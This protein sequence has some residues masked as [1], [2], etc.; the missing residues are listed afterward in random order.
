MYSVSITRM[1]PIFVPPCRKAKRGNA[2][3]P[4]FD[5]GTLKSPIFRSLIC[6]ALTRCV[7]PVGET[8]R[9]L[10]RLRGDAERFEKSVGE[11]CNKCACIDEQSARLPMNRAWH[12]QRT[13]GF[14]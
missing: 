5:G 12:R 4:N 1:P 8:R 14:P 9:Y 6:A 3:T 7:V 2:A 10:R 11:S 13:A